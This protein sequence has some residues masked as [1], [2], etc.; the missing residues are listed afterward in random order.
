MSRNQRERK[1]QEELRTARFRTRIA[2]ASGVLTLLGGLYIATEKKPVKQPV[3]WNVTIPLQ[4]IV[5]PPAVF[6][7][8]RQWRTDKIWEMKP[9]ERRKWIRSAKLVAGDTDG[10]CL[11]MDKNEESA[12]TYHRGPNEARESCDRMHKDGTIERFF[13]D[14]SNR[15]VWDQRQKPNATQPQPGPR[16]TF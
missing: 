8:N 2:V 14:D 5:P 10:F 3:T 15:K 7:P 4:P 9:E 16:V 6:T 12:I 13:A 1:L 11:L